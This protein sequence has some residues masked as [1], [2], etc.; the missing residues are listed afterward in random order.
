MS[1][2][3]WQRGIRGS[4]SAANSFNEWDGA[5][6]LREC[7]DALVEYQS[8]PARSPVSAAEIAAS[9]KL[10]PYLK[11]ALRALGQQDIPYPDF[12]TNAMVINDTL[13][14]SNFLSELLACCDDLEGAREAARDFCKRIEL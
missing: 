5:H 8:V 9:A 11:H 10:R 13:K 4:D 14:W 6:E 12:D 2:L 7:H 3:C 1:Q